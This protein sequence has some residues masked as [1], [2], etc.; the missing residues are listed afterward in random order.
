VA[1]KIT[2]TWRRTNSADII[3]VMTGPIENDDY[4][5]FFAITDG[6]KDVTVILHSGG[7]VAKAAMDIGRLIRSRG[8]ETRVADGNCSSGCFLIWIAG[9]YRSFVGA[10]GRLGLHSAGTPGNP[11]VDW[12]P[13]PHRSE[14]L[15]K[16]IGIY[17]ESMGAPQ[18]VIDLWPQADPTAMNFITYS[19]ARNW[20]LIRERPPITRFWQ[21][22]PWQLMISP[23]PSTFS[24]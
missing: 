23:P 14:K 21:F 24:E 16:E 6:A 13:L 20:G 5:K 12:P 2:A 19:Q 3:V 1:A 9:E 17:L 18:S 8:F 10:K 11:Y 4:S 15:N 22:T 7:G